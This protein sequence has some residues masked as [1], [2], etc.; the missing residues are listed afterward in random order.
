MLLRPPRFVYSANKA[1]NGY[2]IVGLR[3]PQ[4]LA[5]DGS[6]ERDPKKRKRITDALLRL[7]AQ[8]R[9]KIDLEE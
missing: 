4:Q 1:E 8:R 7:L 2:H 6:R 5:A 9:K 3:T